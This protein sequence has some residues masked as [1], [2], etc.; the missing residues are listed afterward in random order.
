MNNTT[1][2]SDLP[3]GNGKPNMKNTLVP[4]QMDS[5]HYKPINVHPNPYGISEENPIRQNP[6]QSY[7][8][9]DDNELRLPDNYREMVMQQSM[10]NSLPSRD[11][12]IDNSEYMNDEE[13]QQ[14]FVPRREKHV[15]FLLDYEHELEKQT[16]KDQEHHR[17]KLLETIYDEIQ[18]AL[19]VSL[20]FFIFQTSLFRKLLWNKFLFLP[21]I[22]NEGNLNLYGVA[23]KSFLFG[24]FF[25]TSQKLATFLTEL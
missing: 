5:D 7:Q 14:N 13:V 11:I 8:Q 10:G 1:N 9:E 4:K 3:I 24:T 16:K 23:F 15:D 6:Q 22:N 20:L 12:P 2:I 17:K 21:I 19:F 18:I 25:Y